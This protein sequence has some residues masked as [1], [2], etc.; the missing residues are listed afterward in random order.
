MSTILFPGKVITDLQRNV[1][2]VIIPLKKAGRLL[3]LEAII[4][5]RI[6]SFIFDT[7]STGLVLNQTYFRDYAPMDAMEAGGITGS[8]G[9]S[10]RIRLNRLQLGNL[11]YEKLYADVMNLGHIE[12]R[13]GIQVFGLFGLN[14]FKDMEMMVDL[15]NNEL[16]LHKIDKDGKRLSGSTEKIIYDITGKVN[17]YENM[18]YVEVVIGEKVLAFC[19]DTGAESNVI[20][21]SLPK[22]VMETVTVLRRSTLQGVGSGTQD[23]LF[24]KMND[25]MIGGEKLEDMQVIM[26]NLTGL[27]QKY[28]YPINGMLGYDFFE[29]GKIYINLV[30]HELGIVLNREV[31][32]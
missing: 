12:N 30:K 9:K 16:Q 29:K 26:T 21:I 10:Y 19:L 31:N 14:L 17:E 25:F 24:G 22:K 6:G 3:L 2:S 11:V 13:R 18:A 15:K 23:V 7:G 32:P 28:G 4:D 20:D 27:S 5:G 1:L 8:A